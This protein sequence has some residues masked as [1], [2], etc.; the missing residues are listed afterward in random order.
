MMSLFSEPPKNFGY[1]RFHKTRYEDPTLPQDSFPIRRENTKK[2]KFLPKI[3][4]K[5]FGGLQ[6]GSGQEYSEGRQLK[7]RT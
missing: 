2:V 5:T 6:Y 3:S 4:N 7:E 1:R